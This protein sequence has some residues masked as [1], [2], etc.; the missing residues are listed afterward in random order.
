MNYRNY[1]WADSITSIINKTECNLSR[2]VISSIKTT[3]DRKKISSNFQSIPNKINILDH[4][5]LTTGNEDYSTTSINFQ[6]FKNYVFEKL[7]SQQKEI[8]KL[9]TKTEQLEISGAKTLIN[10]EDYEIAIETAENKY[11]NE[12]KKVENI[13]RSYVTLENL[14]I[15]E[16]ITK[17]YVAEQMQLFEESFKDLRSVYYNLPNIISKETEE[18]VKGLCKTF[19]TVEELKKVKNNLFR[20]NEKFVQETNEFCQNLD[21]KLSNS[22]EKTQLISNKITDQFE[23]SIKGVK[24]SFKILKKRTERKLTEFEQNLDSFSQKFIDDI[25]FLEKTFKNKLNNSDFAEEIK[26]A[27]QRGREAKKSHEKLINK[28]VQLEQRVSL[29]EE[30]SES[31]SI[32]ELTPAKKSFEPLNSIISEFGSIDTEYTRSKSQSIKIPTNK[33]I[34]Y[35]LFAEITEE[36]TELNAIKKDKVHVSKLNIPLIN[37]ETPPES[38]DNLNDEIIIN[39]DFTRKSESPFEFSKI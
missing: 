5:T 15:S 8:E 12:M 37:S 32:S 35:K 20:E 2:G 16:E 29:L 33:P 11:V 38:K 21:I 39:S 30:T 19:S 22:L 36:F 31:E 17:K 26:E 18:N 4:K 6:D 3:S 28:L 23:R 13:Q 1:S 24:D 10:K 27:K 9:K 34:N 7:Q 25:N 14:R